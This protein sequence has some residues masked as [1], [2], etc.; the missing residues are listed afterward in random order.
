MPVP[1]SGT[2]LARPFDQLARSLADCHMGHLDAERVFGREYVVCLAHHLPDCLG[3][4][5]SASN[6]PTPSP[7]G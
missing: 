2:Y 5:G 6:C 4:R 3:G 1:S 7:A